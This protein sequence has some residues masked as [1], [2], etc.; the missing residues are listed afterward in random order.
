MSINLLVKK[1]V[2]FWNIDQRIFLWYTNNTNDSEYN[3]YAVI[4]GICYHSRNSSAFQEERS[5]ANEN[6]GR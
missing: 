3:E 2:H 4:R 5:Y 6:E 1:L